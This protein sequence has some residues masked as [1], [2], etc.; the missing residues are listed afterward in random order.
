M[1]DC[2]HYLGH[3]VQQ[4]VNAF[5]AW[6]QVI[7]EHEVQRILEIGSGLGGFSLYLLAEMIE[8]GGRFETWDVQGCRNNGTIAR[9]L[10]LEKFSRKGDVFKHEAQIAQF[11]QRKGTSAVLCD[12][13]NKRQEIRTFAPYLKTGD[14]IA[15]HDWGWAVWFDDSRKLGLQKLPECKID[16]LTAF[17]QKV[18]K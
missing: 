4:T 5:P 17:F 14:V 16:P 8:S 7:R 10:E 15:V 13:G 18:D 6:S 2:A 3:K 12:G 1:F 11:I 9:A